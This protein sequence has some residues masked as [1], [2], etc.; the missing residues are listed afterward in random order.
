MN[1]GITTV[2]AAAVAVLGTLISPVLTQRVSARTKLQEYELA[3]RQRQEER[4]IERQRLD[5]VERRSSYTTL[6]TEMRKFRR[7]L[8]NYLHLIRRGRSSEEA[9]AALD[10]VRHSYL[11]CYADAQMIVPDRV[12][13]AAGQANAALAE[14]YGMVRRLDG[15]VSAEVAAG[16]P[17]DEAAVNSALAYLEHVRQRITDTRDVMRAELGVTSPKD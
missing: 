8:I 6:N 10:G 15:S 13:K 4:E 5:F 12:L 11:Q 17:V 3:Q 9:L 1:A 7:E 16:P 2:V 14:A